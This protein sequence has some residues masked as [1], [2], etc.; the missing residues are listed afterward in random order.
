MAIPV[1]NDTN[2]YG[3]VTINGGLYVPAHIFHTGDTDT[4]IGFNAGADTFQIVC[5]GS[6]KSRLE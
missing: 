5:G 3:D 1:L 6:E 4:Y 2:F